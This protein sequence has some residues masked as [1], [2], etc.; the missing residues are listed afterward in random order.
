MVHVRP[1]QD[2]VLSLSDDFYFGKADVQ[3]SS[4]YLKLDRKEKEGNRTLYFFTHSSDIHEW[5]EY[6]N[7]FLGE[8][9]IDYDKSISKLGILLDCTNA[10]KTDQIT[11]INPDCVDLRV[12]PHSVIEA[13]V[14][15]LSFSYQ[16]EWHCEWEPSISGLGL[17]QL[18]SDHLCLR[19][20]NNYWDHALD[21]ASYRY[22]RYPR[23]EPPQGAWP[24]QHHFWFRFCGD[25][26][27][28]SDEC[29]GIEHGGKI[30]LY[31]KSNRFDSNSRSVHFVIDLFLD[32]RKNSSSLLQNTLS[33]KTKDETSPYVWDKP[34][35]PQ[36]PQKTKKKKQP[37]WPV[38]MDVDVV[39]AEQSFEGCKVISGRTVQL[40]HNPCEPCDDDPYGFDADDYHDYYP[41][42]HHNRHWCNHRMRID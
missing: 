34:H 18:G 2:V 17:G 41:F 12:K 42:A 6:S 11:V 27:A 10:D 20:W 5:S 35:K 8:I 29:C 14:Y 21:D 16:D 13:I 26:E 24:K 36:Q 4:S 19:S 15:D 1:G 33:M 9:W 7:V 28:I 25:I 31:G 3:I 32:C 39:L 38:V 40:Q 37:I 23:V 22:A 30:H